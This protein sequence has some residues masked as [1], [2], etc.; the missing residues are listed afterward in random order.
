MNARSTSNRKAKSQRSKKAASASKER[1]RPDEVVERSGIYE[2]FHASHRIT[3]EV[4]L[5]AGQ[6][7][8][9]CSRC[10]DRVRFELVKADKSLNETNAPVVHV[11]GVFVPEAA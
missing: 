11:I 1:F 4:T 8:P 7:F 10:K 2:A 5:I 6:S 3:H 9:H